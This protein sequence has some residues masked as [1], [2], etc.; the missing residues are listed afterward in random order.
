LTEARLSK[1]TQVNNSSDAPT[2]TDIADAT[3]AASPAPTKT[4]VTDSIIT[5][6]RAPRPDV[7]QRPA[8][9]RVIG[10]MVGVAVLALIAVAAYTRRAVS[11]ATIE[12]APTQT[13][14]PSPSQNAT[15]ESQP[16]AEAAPTA[17]SAPT[18][19]V[20][21]A[22]TAPKRANAT[23]PP[24]NA[25]SEGKGAGGG[26]VVV[27]TPKPP[28]TPEGAPAHAEDAQAEFAPN[29]PLTKEE[30]QAV[31]QRV[32]RERRRAMQERRR[33]LEFERRRRRAA[34]PPPNY[35]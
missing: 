28:Q 23:T 13:A 11:P 25:G 27:V 29:R 2:L 5:S 32:E 20:V 9:R 33:A 4:P 7:T 3:R 35:P 21:I 30:L 26:R 10:V 22:P 14:A 18:P 31:M 1:G 6:V 12:Q 15:V 24:R 34:P 19:A 17:A 16:T 8:S